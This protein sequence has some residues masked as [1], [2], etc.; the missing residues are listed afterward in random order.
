MFKKIAQIVIVF[1]MVVAI[2]A[3]SFKVEAAAIEAKFYPDAGV[4]TKVD[5]KTDTVEV[6][7]LN[8]N[9]FAFYGSEDWWNGDIV[10]M[11]LSDNG[12]E[13]VIDDAI[14]N[15]KYSGHVTYINSE[16]SGFYLTTFGVHGWDNYWYEW[17]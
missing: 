2:I 9:I 8:G 5:H 10:A 14:I 4:V 16:E 7:M 11:I 13:T 15:V 6:T 3:A 17:E 1:A 12:T